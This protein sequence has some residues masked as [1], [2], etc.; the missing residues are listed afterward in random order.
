MGHTLHPHAA[1]SSPAICPAWML[2]ETR[3]SPQSQLLQYLQMASQAEYSLF[4]LTAFFAN[5]VEHESRHC[6]GKGLQRQG[7]SY[8]DRVYTAK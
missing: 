7:S 3:L 5:K 8:F 1:V 2:M 6:N 4:F